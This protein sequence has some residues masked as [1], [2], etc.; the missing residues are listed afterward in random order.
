MNKLTSK[1]G[2][3]LVASVMLLLIIATGL[4]SDRQGGT[5]QP[6]QLFRPDGAPVSTLININ[7]VAGWIRNDGWSARVP[8]SGNSGV[9]FPRGTAGAIFQDGIVW[10]GN[11]NDGGS[12]VLRVG[13]Q[14]YNIGTVAGRIVSKGVAASPD[15]PD[16]R[17]YRIRRDYT[18]ADLRQDAAEL[19]EKG[20]NAVTDGDIAAVRAQYGTDWREWP[21]QQGAPYFDSDGDGTYNPAFNADGS[22]K[23]RPAPGEAF[24]ATKHG[25]E[26]G[27]ADADQVIWFA[28]NDLNSGK[29]NGLYGS[30]PIGLELQVTLWGYNRTDPLANV[31]FKKFT[32]IY[33][34]TASTPPGATITDMYVAQWSD[35]DMGDF[36]DDFAGCDTTLSLGYVYNGSANDNEYAKFGL[37]PPAVGYDFLQGPIVPGAPTDSAVFG[38]KRVYGKKN[39]PMTAAFYFAAG[40]VYSDPPFSREGTIQWYNLL[41]GLTPITGT[42]FQYVSQ[43]C[44]I[45]GATKFWLDG[46]PVTGSGR[47][48]GCIESAG[49]RRIGVCTG[50]FTMVLGDTQEIVVGVVGGIGPDFKSS[51]TIMK[52][53]DI[54]VQNA[55]NDLFD[56]PKAPPSP[57][58]RIVQ[59]NQ[60]LILDWGSDEAAVRATEDFDRKG[61]V[62][63]GYNIYQL[64]SPSA[65]FDQATKIATFDKVNGIR[66]IYDDVFNVQTGIIERVIKQRGSDTG[67]KRSMEI[68]NDAIRQFPLVNGQRYYF[69]VTTYGYNPDPTALTHALETSLQIVTGIPQ[70]PNP[71]FRYS[72]SYNDTIVRNN[73][74]PGIKSDGGAVPVVIDPTRMTGQAYKVSF[75]DVPTTFYYGPD[76]GGAYDTLTIDQLNWYFTRGADTLYRSINQGP[77]VPIDPGTHNLTPEVPPIFGNEFDYPIIDGMFL[78]VQGPPPQLNEERSGFTEGGTGN[79]WLR[80]G[81]RYSSSTS[82]LRAQATTAYDVSLLYLGAVGPGVPP[83]QYRDVEFRFGPGRTQKAYRYTRTVT[84]QE[85]GSR[86]KFL[87]YVEVPFQ[88][89]DVS[90]PNSPRQLNCGWRDQI[91]NGVW[92]VGASANAPG[93]LE[94][95][96]VTTTTYDGDNPTTFTYGTDQGKSDNNIMGA[97]LGGSVE[98]N[99]QYMMIAEWMNASGNNADIPQSTILVSPNRVLTANDEFEF[100]A[101]AA[102]SYDAGVAKADASVINAFPNPYYGFN[103]AETSRFQRFITFNHLPQRAEVR[104]FNLAGALVRALMKDDA[105]QFLNWDL[106]N[107][108]GLP[109]ASGIYIAYINMPEIGATK[110]MKL[111]II[112]EQQYLDNF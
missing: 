109:V 28:C 6:G 3:F 66:T 80:G 55:Y 11:V 106:N 32:F 100:T 43:N 84:P 46:D 39:L 29:T 108:T 59:L 34:G 22:P 24:D 45:P 101:P 82:V 50:P 72:A 87:G 67:I 92:N 30:N 7:N 13:G 58:L 69:A 111:V 49:D 98:R 4:A 76:A 73:T 19:F 56:L 64:P 94:I 27:I 33:K 93:N 41:R 14:T 23:L 57:K 48:D 78:S 61:Y 51:I 99:K 95:I 17:I 79:G 53:N 102:P 68:T 86:Y 52:N 104:I 18:T 36:S 20:L 77:T 38:L 60:Q 62:F 21:W 65:S 70:S 107:Q 105:T 110:T 71:G 5:H 12:Q 54:A 44:N 37:K 89:W 81:G 10:G 83:D 103:R 25:D 75:R 35:P 97:G 16:V 63:E 88:V 2:I 8:S 91:L 9:F 40:G 90:D 74:N 112:Q 47:V 26:A 31:Y 42:P 15:D 96:F 1:Y 85:S